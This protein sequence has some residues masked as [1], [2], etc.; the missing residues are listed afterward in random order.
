MDIVEFLTARLDEDQA[1]ARWSGRGR[2][3]WLT[4]RAGPTQKLV[5]AIAVSVDGGTW[6]AN[7]EEVPDPDSVRVVYDPARVLAEVKAKRELIEIAFSH[8][9]KIDGEWGCCHSEESIKAGLCEDE[10]PED[11]AILRTLAKLYDSHPD[12][13]P[14]WSVNA[15]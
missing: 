10:R 7:G 6:I 2:V 11:Q 9:A 13:D 4:Y 8:A 12:Y 14:A 15:T 3:A 5:S 1:V